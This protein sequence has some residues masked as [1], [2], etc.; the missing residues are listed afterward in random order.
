MSHSS[1]GRAAHAGHLL[2]R[3]AEQ[4]L[5]QTTQQFQ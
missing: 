2:Q 4:Q 3:Q 1:L 5:Q